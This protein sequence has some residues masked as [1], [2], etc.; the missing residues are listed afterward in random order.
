MLCLIKYI[1]LGDIGLVGAMQCPGFYMLRH[2]A[3]FAQ[4]MQAYSLFGWTQVLVQ[5]FTG[6]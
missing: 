1:Y 4:Y 2:Q 5:C 6:L 3:L